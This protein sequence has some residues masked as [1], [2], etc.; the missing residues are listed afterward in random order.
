MSQGRN[1]VATTC[2]QPLI[3]THS[4]NK[5]GDKGRRELELESGYNVAH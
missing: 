4:N 2:C 5:A 3:N 1:K